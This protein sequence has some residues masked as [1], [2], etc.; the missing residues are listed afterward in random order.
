MGLQAIPLKLRTTVPGEPSE[1]IPD[2]V[3][4]RS[5]AVPDHL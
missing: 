3:L 2:L 5:I 1:R 4:P